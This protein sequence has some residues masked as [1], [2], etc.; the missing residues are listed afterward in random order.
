MPPAI[1]NTTTQSAVGRIF[2][3][4]PSAPLTTR[5]RP[6]ASVPSS[7]ALAVAK[8]SRRLGVFIAFL[9]RRRRIGN[10]DAPLLVNQLEFG[11]HDDD[12]QQIMDTINRRLSAD[13]GSSRAFFRVTGTTTDGQT[14]SSL[15][16]GRR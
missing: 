6:A 10:S 3:S 2:S 11:Q 4:L 8:K 15:D 12:P 1:H 9:V 5:G 13:D 16:D 14:V 7:A